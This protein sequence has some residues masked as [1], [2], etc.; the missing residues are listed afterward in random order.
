MAQ[1]TS[2]FDA[3]LKEVYA[4]GVRE[5]LNQ[6]TNLL[7]LFIEADLT[8]FAWQGREV[9]LDL[10]SARNLSG[11]KYVPES[12]GLP[13]AG[14]QGTKDLKIPIADVFGRIELTEH[15]M[16][17]SR[18]DKGAFIRAMDLEQKGLVEDIS[19]QRNRALA[20]WGGGVL[21]VITTGA[22][23]TT[24]TLKDPGG[25][26]GTVNVTRFLQPGMYVAISDPTGATVRDVQAIATV[27][28]TTITFANAIN[29][30]TSDIVTLGTNSLSVNE[31]SGV[32]GTESMGVL[33]LAD[34]TTY[35][36]TIFG[37]DRSLAANKF[38]VSQVL[39]NVGTINEDMLQR[40]VDNTEELSGE[41]I[42]KFV[43]H[44]SV[45]REVIKLTQADRRYAAGD[46]PMNFDAGTKAG[47]GK[48]D[49]TFNGW[50]FRTDKDFAYGTIVGLNSNHLIWFPEEKGSWQGA[51]GDPTLLRVNNKANYEA[52]YRIFENFASDKGNSLFRMDGVTATVTAGIYSL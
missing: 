5:E 27:S 50:S 15:V 19:R 31:G 3:T 33:G 21:A 11:V 48:K 9:V 12:G 37:L 28:S 29:T 7:D 22:N 44:S 25:V 30:T 2:A 36:T 45:R 47:S 24:Q 46:G 39:T 13:V 18:S 49:L 20:G 10:H 40:A 43:C 1:T 32:A 23:S 16:K 34:A 4:P 38:F 8:Q 6:K 26:V 51:E 42:N 17:A 52:R 35:V 14:Y 41:Y